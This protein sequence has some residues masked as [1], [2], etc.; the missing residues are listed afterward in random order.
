MKKI[1]SSEIR[2]ANCD[3][4]LN[5]ATKIFAQV[6]L[7]GTRVQSIA[8]DC[9]LPKANVLYYFKSKMGL[10][11]AVLNQIV[12]LWNS[13]FDD[14][15]VEDDPALVL[16]EYIREKMEMSRLRPDASRV[17]AQEIISGA[18]ILKPY[19]ENDLAQWFQS[20]VELIDGWIE[21][22]KMKPVNPRFLLFHIWSSTQHYAD[23]G[24]QITGLN[25]ASMA[26]SDYQEATK[27]LVESILSSCGLTVPEV[28]NSF[29]RS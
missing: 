2:T 1:S 28:D 22:G 7:A 3:K 10:Y 14:A 13:L 25:R 23:F 18:P 21:Q 9:G 24:A 6:G 26:E 27:Y 8:D 20:R 29:K 16:S 5:S 17:F 15:T 11:E 4:I 19:L 12:T